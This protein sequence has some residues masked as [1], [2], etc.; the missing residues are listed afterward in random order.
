MAARRL[1]AAALLLLLVAATIGAGATTGAPTD[2]RGLLQGTVPGGLAAVWDRLR[3]G[4]GEEDGEQTPPLSTSLS[5]AVDS[6]AG[7][8]TSLLGSDDAVAARARLAQAAAARQQQQQGVAAAARAGAGAAMMMP[9]AGGGVQGAA[10][11]ARAAAADAAAGAAA[12][13]RR[14]TTAAASSGP[15]RLTTAYDPAAP[16]HGVGIPLDAASYQAQC[17][18]VVVPAGVA[19]AI[20]A[21]QD[22]SATGGAAFAV[23]VS[24]LATNLPANLSLVSL[25]GGADAPLPAGVNLTA[26]PA[27]QQAVLAALANVS[28]VSDIRNVSQLF[29]ADASIAANG[30]ALAALGANNVAAL[31]SN[32]T[33]ACSQFTTT[34]AVCVCPHDY[35]G[36]NCSTPRH[37]T[38]AVMVSDPLHTACVAVNGAGFGVPSEEVARGRDVVISS[39]GA[40]VHNA[41]L[42][43][44]GA[45]SGA[46]APLTLAALTSAASYLGVARPR[47]SVTDANSIPPPPD[48]TSG[49]GGY[50]ATLAGAPP[51][52]FL[53]VHASP[54]GPA[55]G[56]AARLPFALR[57]T[58]TFQAV[59]ATAHLASGDVLVN[60]T[61][62]SY[63]VASYLAPNTTAAVAA[64]YTPP[65]LPPTAAPSLS[66]NTTALTDTYI[67]TAL[68]A[69]GR[70]RANAT[71]PAP[72]WGLL[73]A[74]RQLRY[75]VGSADT[76]QFALSAPPPLPLALRLRALSP[77]YLSDTSGV[78]TSVIP[79]GALGGAYDVW[80]HLSAAA[81]ASDADY[82]AGGRL[83]LEAQVV[84]M[85]DGWAPSPHTPPAEAA[86][87]AAAVLAAAG[88]SDWVP[89]PAPA[90]AALL[91]PVA[92]A[93][94][95][96]PRLLLSS[97]SAFMVDDSS[98]KNPT[99]TSVTPVVLGAALGVGV[100][101]VLGAGGAWLWW[102]R[103]KRAA[104][105]RERE[106]V[107]DRIMA[108][109]EAEAR[110]TAAHH[111]A[112]MLG[113]DA[114]PPG[115]DAPPPR[116]PGSGGSSSRGSSG[117]PSR[118]NS[119]RHRAAGGRSS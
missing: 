33:A 17:N 4:G 47:S 5:S 6:V 79:V 105:A 40:N 18:G 96:L 78:S 68:A 51:C 20:T 22:G 115:D 50:R 27:A 103:R 41:S 118:T 31:L 90:L 55:G 117:P 23:A 74:E 119:V 107:Q 86:A 16:C 56:Q 75:V 65:R 83:A 102:R 49:W 64:R 110:E 11:R 76:P 92:A 88:Y 89:L 84:M 58:C 38:C 95:G 94:A 34:A 45:R 98:W 82:W 73:C 32:T 35:T 59:N 44:C 62:V 43:R 12:G 80:A 63:L 116:A 77:T 106:A 54:C 97:L 113:G 19:D 46:A 39:L 7:L 93:T 14:T 8:M 71:G 1:P 112:A 67:D 85:P 2:A 13:G 99:A 26:L 53:D 15:R 91:D 3:G 21:L 101:L 42:P 57:V 114:A 9:S 29:P 37:Y 70:V 28:S 72:Y 104:A 48:V 87:G 52:M 24:T 109:V 10:R 61:G 30:A 100:P 108:A 69:S 36:T 81:L 66:C 60:A 111:M 25:A